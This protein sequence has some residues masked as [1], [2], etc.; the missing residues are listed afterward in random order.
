VRRA[1]G[2]PG[3]ESLELIEALRRVD[4]PYVLTHHETAAGFM[5]AATAQ[6]SGVPGVCIVTRGPGAMNLYPSIATAYL[7]RRAV[8]AISGDHPPAGT[9]TARPRDTHQRLPLVDL[10]APVTKWAGRLGP[11]NLAETLGQSWQAALQGRPGP[12]F[13]SFASADAERVMPSDAPAPDA[14]SDHSVDPVGPMLGAAMIRIQAAHRP[15]LVAGIGVARDGVD[16]EL[17]ALAEH[18]GCPVIVTQQVKGW[19]PEDHPLFAGTFGLYHDEPLH[20]LMVEADLIVAVGLD[21]ADFYK[22]WRATTPVVSLADGEADD[23]TF[24]P[25]VASDGDLAE[26]LRRARELTGPSEWPEDRATAARR[27]MVEIIRPR[28][29]HAP[30]GDGRRMPPQ[31]AISELRRAFPRDGILTVDVG[32]HKLVVVQQ[33]RTSR[34]NSFICSNGLSPMGTGLP[35]AIG[36]QL[37]RPDA[38][39]ACVL[40]DGGFLM[41]TG[42]LETVARLKLPIVLLLMVDDALSSIKVKQVRKDYPSSGVEFSRPDYGAIARGFGFDHARVADRA[43]CRAALERALAGERPALIEAIVDPDEYEA[44]Q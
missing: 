22:R 40:G 16:R 24:Q 30:D 19:F 25:T 2:I 8:V 20:E 32:S 15:L 38:R 7:D 26:Q 1:F 29:A 3:G 23:A 43:A 4:I 28:G 13:W 11:G 35:F 27:A 12:I 36:A 33:W 14:W 17:V 42:E 44:T 31:V 39:V 41:Y 34:P 9:A 10:Y 21:G 6:L 5:A 18:L 37:E